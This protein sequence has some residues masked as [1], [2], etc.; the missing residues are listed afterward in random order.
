MGCLG[1]KVSTIFT[2]TLQMCLS[3]FVISEIVECLDYVNEF[4]IT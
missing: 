2:S 3:I 1:D 4:N